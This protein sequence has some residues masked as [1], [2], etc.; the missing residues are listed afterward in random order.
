MKLQ[1]RRA[2]AMLLALGAWL[3]S[4]IPLAAGLLWGT[5]LRCDD[6]CG[7]GGWRQ[8]DEAW[9]WDAVAALGVVVFIAATAMLVFVWRAKR[10]AA[11]LTYAVGVVAFIALGSLVSSNW[12]EHPDRISAGEAA[13]YVIGFG[14][15]LAATVLT[16]R[17][18][19]V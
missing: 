11:V 13:F 14:A 16:V 1:M 6:A 18:G 8:S 15:P 12:Y 10:L 9:Q 4:F 17:R 19:R 3:V 5:K 7:G 2:L